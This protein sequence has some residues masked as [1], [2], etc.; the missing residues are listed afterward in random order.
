[1]HPTDRMNWHEC[2]AWLAGHLSTRGIPAAA[3]ATGEHTSTTVVRLSIGPDEAD[4]THT[5]Q[6]TLDYDFI[7]WAILEA[8]TGRAVRADRWFAP[9]GACAERVA[10]LL[11]GKSARILPAPLPSDAVATAPVDTPLIVW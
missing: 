8:R 7:N 6:V 11:N 2:A 5:L 4:H 10:I 3:V 9:P 1:M